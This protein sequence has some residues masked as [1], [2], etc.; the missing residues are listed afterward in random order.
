MVLFKSPFIHF[1][2]I[3]SKLLESI[4]ENLYIGIFNLKYELRFGGLLGG[5]FWEVENIALVMGDIT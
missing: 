4:L 2:H 5:E 3:I 1:V